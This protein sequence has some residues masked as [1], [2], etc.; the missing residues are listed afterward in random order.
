MQTQPSQATVDRK[1]NAH[2]DTPRLRDRTLTGLC[3]VY[4]ENY[5]LLLR[6]MPAL[7]DVKRHAEWT[8]DEIVHLSATVDEPSLRC[9]VTESSPYTTTLSLTHHF[10]EGEAW[11]ADP[12]LSV[13]VYHDARQAET[14]NCGRNAHCEILRQFR[15]NARSGMERRWQVNIL[16]NKWLHYLLARE[17]RFPV[18]T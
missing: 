6:L 8:D 3:Q 13:R 11:V 2:P 16:L 7:V 10:F 12:D 18:I 1:Q 4:D 9:W 5:Q 17:H 14:L 15:G